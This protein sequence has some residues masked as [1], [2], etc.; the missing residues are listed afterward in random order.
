MTTACASLLN[1]AFMMEVKV[2]FKLVAYCS[3]SLSH[4]SQARFT[5]YDT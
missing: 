4:L 3:E 1:K 2:T 5:L